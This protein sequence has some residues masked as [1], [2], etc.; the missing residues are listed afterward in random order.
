MLIQKRLKNGMVPTKTMVDGLTGMGLGDRIIRNA[1]KE[2][3]IKSVR[4]GGQWHW[5]LPDTEIEELQ[6]DKRR[7]K[8]ENS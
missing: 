3:G 5:T 2:L 8:K 1:K 7:E 4:K 6:N